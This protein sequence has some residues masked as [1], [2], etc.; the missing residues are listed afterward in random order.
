MERHMEREQAP[1]N[2][3]HEI[4]IPENKALAYLKKNGGDG[5]SVILESTPTPPNVLKKGRLN[6]NKNWFFTWNNYP[7]N[8]VETLERVFKVFAKAY[9][10]Q[11]E[12]GASGTPHIQG[13]IELK[14]AG[15]PTEMKLDKA[16]HWEATR[17]TKHATAY[18]AKDDTRVG[19]EVYSF[20]V[21]KKVTPL[22]TISVLK[23]WQSQ[24]LEL[25]EPEIP[26]DRTVHWIYDQQG[27]MGKTVFSK[28]LFSEQQAVIATGG[29]AKDIACLLACLVKDG[30]DLNDKTTFIFNF[31]RSTEG[32]SWKAIEMVKD[33]MITSP[34]YESSTL[35]FNSPHVIC[36]SNEMP[37]LTK[38][39]ADRWVIW[40]IV[41]DE[42]VHSMGKRI[43]LSKDKIASTEVS[44]TSNSSADEALHT[45]INLS[46]MKPEELEYPWDT[47]LNELEILR[48]DEQ[49]VPPWDHKKEMNK[50][51]TVI[52]T[53]KK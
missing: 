40:T 34:K 28:Y 11:K 39:S 7:S 30:R 31:P 38:L 23:P 12:V 35:V 13:C 16:I 45:A 9:T 53:I 26:D 8:A 24:V 49:V 48:Y 25:I 42:L 27:C 20:P 1:D 41:N 4:E 17:S 36:F 22:R 6:Q 19:G 52:D 14:K 29:G 21:I 37:D 33:G 51:I 2:I 5:E 43:A 44:D 10:F 18:C 3:C 47:I 15:R 50:V 32:I 46:L